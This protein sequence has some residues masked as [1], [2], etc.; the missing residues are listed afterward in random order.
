MIMREVFYEETA[1]N[2]K[3]DKQKSIYNIFKVLSWLSF[4]GGMMWFLIA[5]FTIDFNTGALVLALIFSLVPP[6]LVFLCG[7]F[8]AI[9]R[10]KFCVE[11]D[12]T[13][14]N[15]KFIFSKIINNLKRVEASSFE[16]SNVERIGL[17]SDEVF[18]RYNGNKE[19]KVKFLT[20]N[21]TPLEDKHFYYIVATVNA[22]KFVYIIEVTK[23]FM[24]NVRMIA[25]SYLFDGEIK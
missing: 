18:Q 21:D 24:L 12:Y 16:L 5:L 14:A 25:K 1:N 9:V 20:P 13:F 15:G 10:D 6:I 19:V 4:V 11:Y 3:F 22:Q 7:V 17:F 2:G 8:F 23:T